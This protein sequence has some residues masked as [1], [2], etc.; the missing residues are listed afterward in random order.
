[1]GIAKYIDFNYKK[2]NTV[3]NIAVIVILVTH[4]LHLMDSQK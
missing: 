1:M 3:F 2:Y 4:I